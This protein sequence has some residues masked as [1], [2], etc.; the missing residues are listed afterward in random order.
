MGRPADGGSVCREENPDAKQL[1]VVVPLVVH[2]GHRGFSWSH[3]TDLGTLIEADD[4][5]RMALGDCIPQFSILLDD[6]AAVDA[7]TLWSRKIS[8]PAAMAL[9]LLSSTY[10]NPNLSGTLSDTILDTVRK[11]NTEQLETWFTRGLTAKTLDEVF[12]G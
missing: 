12:A 1:P 10:K 5:I 7:P 4:A 6:L 8:A 9:A 3:P 11:A 2:T